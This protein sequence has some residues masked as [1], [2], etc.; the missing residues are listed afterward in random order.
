MGSTRAV[1]LSCGGG[2]GPARCW[3]RTHGR[4]RIIGESSEGVID[5]SERSGKKPCTEI[6]PDRQV[7]SVPG[8]WFHLF[9][10][11]GHRLDA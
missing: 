1:Y 11:K 10:E 7:D 2:K 4:N 6:Q 5:P 9:I 8:F 3:V